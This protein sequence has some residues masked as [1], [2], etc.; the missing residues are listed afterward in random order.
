LFGQS[1]QQQHQIHSFIQQQR[2]TNS[3]WARE[4]S[5]RVRVRVSFPIS[6]GGYR[7]P[8]LPPTMAPRRRTSSSSTCR[9][10]FSFLRRGR[11][12][13]FHS[14][15]FISKIQFIYSIRFDAIRLG[16]NGIH[17]WSS[18]RCKRERTS[19]SSSMVTWF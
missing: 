16:S 5:Y 8:P 13:H 10:S 18:R 3:N 1:R 19:E 11:Y 9:D 7:N 15:L 4:C 14:F 6:H 17:N 12:L 2:V